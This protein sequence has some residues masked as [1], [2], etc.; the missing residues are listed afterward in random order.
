MWKGKCCN[1]VDSAR[2]KTKEE[3]YILGILTCFQL[4]SFHYL[5]LRVTLGKA[6]L[7]RSPRF[8]P[9]SSSSSLPL[10]SSSSPLRGVALS[11]CGLTSGIK[12][13]RFRLPGS[14]IM[15]IKTTKCNHFCLVASVTN[16]EVFNNPEAQVRWVC[17]GQHLDHIRVPTSWCEFFVLL[18]IS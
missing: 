2:V 10:P 18:L 14:H 16:Q 15:H 13:K 1:T 4:W 3:P 8:P 17:C 9:S 7:P 11:H 5:F 12:W 6:T